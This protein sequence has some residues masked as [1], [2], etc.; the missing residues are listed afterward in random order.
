MYSRIG[1]KTLGSHL[2]QFIDSVS[3][4]SVQDYIEYLQKDSIP[5]LTI[6]RRLS[7]LR[8]FFA[9]CIKRQ[10]LEVNP[11][12]GIRTLEKPALQTEIKVIP[13][14]IEPIN[15][16]LSIEDDFIEFMKSKGEEVE[17]SLIAEFRLYI[18]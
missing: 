11:M 4:E 17:P 16:E 15:Q 1:T 12:E 3:H 13:T 8:K 5:V 7:T 14:Q 18:E 2:D 10:I 9:F 6:N